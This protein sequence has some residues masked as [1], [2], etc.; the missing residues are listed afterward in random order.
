MVITWRADDIVNDN[1]LRTGNYDLYALDVTMT[2]T[3]AIRIAMAISDK[4][5][6][7][8]LT[9]TSQWQRQW[10]WQLPDNDEAYGQVAEDSGKEE[11]HVEKRHRDDHLQYLQFSR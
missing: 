2:M 4:N 1:A 3:E 7:N 10:Q 9:M 5:N 6:G 11:N 8:N